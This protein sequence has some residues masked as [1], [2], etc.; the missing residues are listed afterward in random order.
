MKRNPRELDSNELLGHTR[1]LRGLAKAMVGDEHAAQDVVQDA[2]VTAME[3]P[4]KPGWSI[5]RWLSGITRNHARDHVREERRRNLR[6]QVAAKPDV[7]EGDDSLVRVDLLQHLLVHV[8][9]LEEPYRSTILLR[10]FDGLSP[11]AVA[12]RQGV[13]Y[14]TVRT[15]LRHSIE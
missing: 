4:S 6:E 15:R 11:K 1:A 3:K 10:F 8:R 2:F 13:P 9:G 5:G 7:A 12:T 14:A